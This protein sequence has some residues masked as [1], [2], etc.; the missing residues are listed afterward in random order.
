MAQNYQYSEISGNIF[1]IS[2]DNTDRETQYDI[3]F[4]TITL[5]RETFRL[6]IWSPGLDKF[7]SRRMDQVVTIMTSLAHCS[8]LLHERERFSE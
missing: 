4:I 6:N 3:T 7:G 5:P 8:T 2:S 1:I